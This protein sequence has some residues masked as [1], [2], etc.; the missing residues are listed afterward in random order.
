MSAISLKQLY[1][2][3]IW[4]GLLL[5]SFII[6]CL[7]ADKEFVVKNQYI[8]LK[9]IPRTPNQMAAFYEA[10]G[11]SQQAIA[12][13]RKGCFIT[14]IIRNNSEEVV[15]LEL[16]RWEFGRKRFSRKDLRQVWQSL[17][18][19]KANQSTFFWTQLPEVRDLRPDEPVGG[20]IVL[21]R[22]KGKI[23]VNSNF[24]LGAKKQK[25]QFSLKLEGVQCAEE[26]K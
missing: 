9:L 18:V 5:F 14:V 24:Y 21:L 25:G 7:A 17:S 13:I 8:S 12:E 2:L 1:Q 20:N 3:P 16:A 15:W 6:N 19:P 4:V 10:R 26:P 22:K 23:T 11:F